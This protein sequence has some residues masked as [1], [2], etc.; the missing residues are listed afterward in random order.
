MDGAPIIE[1][2]FFLLNDEKKRNEIEKKKKRGPSFEIL[3]VRLI[4]MF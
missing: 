2:I 4:F 1:Q 3:F